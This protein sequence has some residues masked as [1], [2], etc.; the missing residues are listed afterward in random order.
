MESMESSRVIEQL[1]VDPP[2]GT[3]PMKS[4]STDSNAFVGTQPLK[5]DDGYTA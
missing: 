3:V 4:I 5:S 2:G 1:N